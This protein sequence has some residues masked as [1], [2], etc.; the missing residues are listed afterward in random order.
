MSSP[1]VSERA[2]STYCSI[3]AR[4]ACTAFSVRVGKPSSDTVDTA[5]QTVIPCP[6]ENSMIRSC[7]FSPIPRVG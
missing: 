3:I 7:V 2:A 1:G 6:R 5:S 4:K